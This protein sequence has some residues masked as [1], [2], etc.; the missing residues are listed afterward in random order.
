MAQE[1][2]Q[3]ITVTPALKELRD[4]QRRIER[5]TIFVVAGVVSL[6][7]FLAVLIPSG[8]IG[9][10]GDLI[11]RLE[12][13]GDMSRNTAKMCKDPRN[14]N[15]AFCQ[16]KASKHEADWREISRFNGGQSNKF[17]LHGKE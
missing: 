12:Y 17:T 3:I 4:R 7:L 1:A 15:T 8:A 5:L 10:A 16:S 13:G 9:G 11:F 2:T 14:K 6:I